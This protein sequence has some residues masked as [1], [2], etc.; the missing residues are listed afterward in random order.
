MSRAT[1]P[2]V[3]MLLALPP[4][5]GL[6]SDRQ[7]FSLTH[8]FDIGGGGCIGEIRVFEGVHSPPS[9]PSHQRAR[10]LPRSG[11]TEPANRHFLTTVGCTNEQ[12][13]ISIDGKGYL[14]ELPRIE[15]FGQPVTYLSDNASSPRVRIDHLGTLRTVHF[16]ETECTQVVE[17]VRVHIEFNGK[18]RSVL[19]TAVGS[20]P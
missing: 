16:K 19:G 4:M 13:G 6:A 11:P 2:F 20:C 12:V 3:A 8:V 18:T 10:P 1:L 14:L 17:R 9:F 5:G 7:P 15:K